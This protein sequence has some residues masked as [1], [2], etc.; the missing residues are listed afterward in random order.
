MCLPILITSWSLPFLIPVQTMLSYYLASAYSTSYFFSGILYLSHFPTG[1]LHWNF[2]FAWMLLRWSS[3]PALNFSF[4]EFHG[5]E[6]K[7]PQSQLQSDR[8]ML[9]FPPW[10]ISN[11]HSLKIHSHLPQ[12]VILLTPEKFRD[13]GETS[14]IQTVKLSL[15]LKSTS[16]FSWCQGHLSYKASQIPSLLLAPFCPIS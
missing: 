9:L 12:C 7:G 2:Q 5:L 10:A 13:P 3:H 8:R 4:E 11:L 15:S 1:P 6:Q 16:S 14:S